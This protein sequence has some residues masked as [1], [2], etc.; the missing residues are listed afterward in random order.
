MRLLCVVS[1]GFVI[2]ADSAVSRLELAAQGRSHGY[3]DGILMLHYTWTRTVP[4]L[5]L[6]RRYDLLLY[7]TGLFALVEVCLI[8]CLCLPWLIFDR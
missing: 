4:F 8:C 1:L 5:C 2:D 6:T 3:P 7:V